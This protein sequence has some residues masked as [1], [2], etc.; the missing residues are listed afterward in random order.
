[1]RDRIVLQSTRVA[2]DALPFRNPTSQVQGVDIEYSS[3][4]GRN[5]VSAIAAGFEKKTTVSA[6]A[7]AGVKGIGEAKASVVDETTIRASYENT[8]GRS[9]TRAARR[10]S[11]SWRSLRIRRA[12]V[13]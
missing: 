5:E 3:A 13:G 2:D 11:T 9:A 6:E 1:M 7:S 10:K 12:R 4:Q 8:T